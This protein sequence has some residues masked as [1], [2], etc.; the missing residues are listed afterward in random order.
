MPRM[1]TTRTIT[2]QMPVSF[3][4]MS[5]SQVLMDGLTDRVAEIEHD[6]CGYGNYDSQ[7]SEG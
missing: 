6:E 2:E 1:A 5:L 4:R 7:E 3:A